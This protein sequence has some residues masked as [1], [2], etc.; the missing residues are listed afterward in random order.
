M[1]LSEVRKNYAQ[2]K[3]RI[4]EKGVT[5]IAVSKTMPF[6]FIQS[7][8]ELGHRDFGENYA[9]ELNEKAEFARL[10]GLHDIRWHFIG[11]LQGN[12]IKL[13]LPWVFAIHTLDSIDRALDVQKKWEQLGRDETEKLK[14]FFEINIDREESKS[15]FLPENFQS[16]PDADL[17]KIDKLDLLG[18]MCIPRMHQEDPSEP[19]ER[20]RELSVTR[21]I[22]I[23]PALSMGMSGDF[24]AAIACGATH[25][26]IGS[27]IFGERSG[28]NQPDY[29]K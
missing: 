5:L 14:V 28:K 18:L 19:F 20:M 22:G 8:Y 9:Q 12:K 3:A 7:L 17:L 16:L 13:I 23:G 11:H 6:E 2:V 21:P 4:P 25:V 24:E 10:M 26:R 1:V 15:G 29:P 27:L